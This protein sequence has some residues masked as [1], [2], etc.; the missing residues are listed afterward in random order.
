MAKEMNNKV[1]GPS[2]RR[3]LL[4]GG[5]GS[6]A[7]GIITLIYELDDKSGF[8][9]EHDLVSNRSAVSQANPVG[10]SSFSSSPG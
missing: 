1:N 7:M 10:R 9:R 8:S 5:I 4:A 6:A 2:R 3:F